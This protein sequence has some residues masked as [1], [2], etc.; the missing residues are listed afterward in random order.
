M[1]RRMHRAILFLLLLGFSNNA[2]AQ[3]TPMESVRDAVVHA[4]ES[5]WIVAIGENHGHVEFYEQLAELLADVK[6]QAVVDD[7]AVEYGNGLY[8]GVMDRY[9]S[10]ASVPYDSVKLAWRNSIVSP[11]TVWD[12][13][14]YEQFL[15]RVRE[16]NLSRTDGRQYRVVLADSP[17]D[18]D[19]VTSIDDLRPFFNRSVAMT[20]SVQREILSRGRRGLLIAGGAHLTRVNMVRKNRN[21]VPTA[22]V[23]VAS[24]LAMRHPGALFVIKSLGNGRAVNHS[25]LTDVQPGSLI[26][27][28]D[29][30]VASVEANKIS[31]MKNFDGSP[32]DAYGS[33]TL[34]DLS[35]ALIY[36]GTRENNHFVDAP[37]SVYQ[38]DDFW[39]ELNR[40]SNLTGRG[41]MDPELRK[42]Q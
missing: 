25:L 1:N 8:Q 34:S 2:L 9:I 3:T 20:N 24:R 39:T 12:S 29:P 11:N 33:A 26:L 6:V 7:I 28:S 18:W 22:E 13:P 38:D 23:S 37:A 31:S 35:D 15:Q 4:L 5:R 42:D 41:D 19:T 14:V 17:V 16:V 27:T 30:R 10:G 36:W 32:F 21:G 40:R